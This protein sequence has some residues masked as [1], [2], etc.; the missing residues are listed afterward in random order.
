MLYFAYGSNLCIDHMRRRCPE[1]EPLRAMPVKDAA[2]VFRGVADVTLRKNSFVQG[3]L[4]RITDECEKSLDR[5]EGVASKLYLKRY[6]Q[7]RNEKGAVEDCLLYQMRIS[8]GIM[9]PAEAYLETIAQGY[10]DFDLDL[11]Y[12]DAALQES[13]GSKKITE[14]LRERHVRR[15]RPKLASPAPRKLRFERNEFG[16]GGLA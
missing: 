5:F 12:L 14:T 6:L 13:W 7:V 16:T 15:G 4:W 3:G 1:A 8:K 11:A 10:R 2:L 9:P